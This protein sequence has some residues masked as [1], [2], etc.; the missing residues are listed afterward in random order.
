M[1]SKPKSSVRL[2]GNYFNMFTCNVGL[3]QGGF[4]S[5][6]LYSL[7]VN[8]TEVELINHGCQAYELKTLNL[9]LLMYADD[10]VVLRE[11][12]EDL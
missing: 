3:M 12:V 10:T 4:L 6:L 7:Y 1:Y 5:L 11:N 2:D 8:D 9:F